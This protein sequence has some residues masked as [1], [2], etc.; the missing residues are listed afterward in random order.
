MFAIC[1]DEMK[2]SVIEK[3]EVDIPEFALLHQGAQNYIG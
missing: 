1:N 2:C 3:Y